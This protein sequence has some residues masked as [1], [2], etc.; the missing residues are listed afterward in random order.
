MPTKTS[1]TRLQALGDLKKSKEILTKKEVVSK[2]KKFGDTKQAQADIAKSHIAVPKPPTK[3]DL[4]L[5]DITRL[6]GP[7]LGKKYAE[8]VEYYSWLAYELAIAEIEEVNNEIIYD[9]TFSVIL[10]EDIIQG[11]TSREDRDA[12]A[13]THRETTR[14][15][16]EKGKAHTK[17]HLLR[18]ICAGVL[19]KVDA[20]SREITRRQGY[21]KHSMRKHSTY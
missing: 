13:K 19:K 6:E 11:L 1:E 20:L 4:K 5:G 21:E 8:F 3:V 12:A 9:H 7:A 18:S 2:L 14:A 16:L 15:L 10:I 17:A